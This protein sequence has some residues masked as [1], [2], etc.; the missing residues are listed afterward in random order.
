MDSLSKGAMESEGETG[1][2]ISSVKWYILIDFLLFMYERIDLWSE[3]GKGLF[4]YH[5]LYVCLLRCFILMKCFFDLDWQ[6]YLRNQFD[7]G[8][9]GGGFDVCL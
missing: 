4:I 3:L 9:F 8:V 5:S 1:V 6:A 2:S 7:W